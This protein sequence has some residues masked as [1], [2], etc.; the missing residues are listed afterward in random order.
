MLSFWLIATGMVLA[1]SLTILVPLWHHRPRAA[2]SRTEVNTEIFRER[3]AELQTEHREGRI[4][5]SQLSQLRT[6]LER[7]LL[8]DVPE[9]PERRGND[10]RVPRVAATCLAL[11][12]PLLGLG[13]FY[14]SG[15]RG[16]PQEWI[17]LQAR[18]SDP[19]E[20]AVSRPENLPPEA[21]DDPT[22][23]TRVLQAQLLADGMKDPD[24][25]LLLGTRYLSLQAPNPA[26]AT[27]HRAHELAPQRPDIQLAYAQ[28]M[29]M[30]DAGR[31]S[32]D[33][34]RLLGQVLKAYPE[35]QGALMLLGFGAFNTGLYGDAIQAWRQLLS[36]RNPGSEGA[37]VLRN[38]IARAQALLT[39]SEGQN[40]PAADS[41]KPVPDASPTRITVTVDLLPE[42][43]QGLAPE[44]TLFV[45]A[46][47]AQGPPMPLAAIRQP[48]Q[49]FPIQV[50]LDDTL[51]ML[52][53][54]KLSDFENVVVGARISK[55][56]DV[57]AKP[58]DF[59]G[60]SGMLSLAGGPQSVSVTI[61]QIVP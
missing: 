7:T 20:R 37:R 41:A 14:L 56:G 16:A 9:E 28:A 34:A 10:G 27:L 61:D 35:H 31:L 12:I 3:L 1:A 17:A 46:K 54:L 60:T 8:A 21:Q 58:G 43:R 11:V 40:S 24:G 29:M 52:P 45:F 23:F 51:A 53:S 42:L 22:G 13:Y 25:L 33:S 50:V 59:E 49:D 36:L 32:Q 39:Q 57:Q 2:T 30:A 55:A 47:A 19:V 15:F 26:L 48:A 38:S 18:L 44:D 4:D 5:A 6:E